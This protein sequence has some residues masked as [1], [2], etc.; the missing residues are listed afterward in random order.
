MCLQQMQILFNVGKFF[1]LSPSTVEVKPIS[2]L[3]KVYAMIMLSTLTIW[4]FDSIS[5]KNFYTQYIHIKMIVSLLTDIVLLSIYVTGVID[6]TFRKKDHWFRLMK[7]LKIIHLCDN[8]GRR[9]KN[10][11]TFLMG[12]G[13]YFVIMSFTTFTWYDLR[14]VR[15]FREFSCT[16]ALIYTKYLQKFILYVI[17]NM[18]ADKYHSLCQQ[19][20]SLMD[21]SNTQQIV[22][23]L[24]GMKYFIEVLKDTVNIFNGIFGWPITLILT[25]TILH[26]LNYLD[27]SF[28]TIVNLDK[29]FIINS[30]ISNVMLLIFDFV[31]DVC[32]DYSKFDIF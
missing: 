3:Q 23:V 1:A 29:M 14:G 26:L 20:R 27:Y 19:L 15:F 30:V 21:K 11:T 18:I 8:R 28:I 2:Q 31:S 16:M 9:M 10:C 4:M 17:L 12:H 24:R 32:I 6:V 22:A 5:Y 7:N 25:F 13:I